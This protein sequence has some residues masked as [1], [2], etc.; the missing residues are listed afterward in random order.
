MILPYN[1]FGLI[2]EGFKGIATESTENRCFRAPHC[3]FTTPLRETPANI[4]TNLI[5]PET[6]V[7]GYIYVADNKGLSLFKFVWWA[8]KAQV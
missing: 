2:S 4:H 6:R 3:C 7:P 8:P 5:L 1:N